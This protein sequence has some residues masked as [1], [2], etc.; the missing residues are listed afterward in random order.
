MTCRKFKKK[1]KNSRKKPQKK[2]KIK[3]KIKFS[4]LVSNQHVNTVYFCLTKS[5]VA[6]WPSD[7]SSPGV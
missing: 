7:C 1:K 5:A 3:K 4:M 2:K 6:L